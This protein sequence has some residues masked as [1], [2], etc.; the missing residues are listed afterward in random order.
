MASA[1]GNSKFVADFEA[2]RS[3]LRKL[4]VMRIGRL[5]SADQTRLRGH[6]S[7]M[8]FITQPLGLGDSEKALVDLRREGGG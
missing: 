4:Q 5:P 6:E 3:G 2:Q 8:G 1:Q 7:Q